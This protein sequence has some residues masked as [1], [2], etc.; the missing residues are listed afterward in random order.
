MKKKFNPKEYQNKARIYCPVAGAV[1]IQRLW[2]WDSERSEYA[3]PERGKCF[4]ARRWGA[5]SEGKRTRCKQS[6]E[7]LNEARDWQA[8]IKIDEPTK[9]SAEQQTIRKGPLFGEIVEIWQRRVFP[10]LAES[11]SV[12][13]EKIIRLYMG[14]LLPLSIYELT[15]QRVDLWIDE[16]K[17]PNGRPMQSTRRKS[18][19]HELT[20]LGIVLK[21]YSEYHDDLEFRLPIKQRHRDAIE[22]NR[23]SQVKPKDLSMEEF[24]RFREKL[25][26]HRYGEIMAAMATVQYF[27]ALRVSEVAGLYWEDMRFD[28]A[29]PRNSRMQV[30]RYVCWPRKKGLSSSVKSGFKNS[31]ANDG[32][33]EQPIFPETYQALVQL[34]SEGKKGLVFAQEGAH[35]EYRQIQYAYDK[36]FKKAGLPYTATHV[37]RHGGCR[38]VYNETSDLE[39]AKQLL[40]NSSV[41]TTLV[42]AK[43]QASA[44]T[45]VSDN[46]WD[47]FEQE[48]GRKWSQM[49]ANWLD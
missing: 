9:L 21:Y 19:D 27:Q 14:S 2:V 39:V 11:T 5:N 15:P 12:A 30:T 13:Y 18:F 49:V 47:R 34:Y 1:R 48:S 3:P 26:E 10:T 6:F 38:V 32:I 22:L 40:G 37:M 25:K 17:D 28:F 29:A 46:H 4:E 45:K 23:P 33:K 20:L 24:F 42:Y 31:E 7:S 41:Q 43:R 44:L 35:F 16:L 36:A 8:F